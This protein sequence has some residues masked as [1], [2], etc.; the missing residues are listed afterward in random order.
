M[1]AL[2]EPSSYYVSTADWTA[3]RTRAAFEK[4]FLALL[5][6]AR[7]PDMEFCWSSEIESLLWTPGSQPAWASDRA[8]RQRFVEVYFK[9]IRPVLST[10]PI[11]SHSETATLSP[12]VIDEVEVTS[13]KTESLRIAASLV[14]SDNQFVIL[15]GHP[16][17]TR[18]AVVATT[19]MSLEVAVCCDAS[20]VLGLVAQTGR[21]WPRSGS[22]ANTL[23]LAIDV[24]HRS[25]S[26]ASRPF[27]YEYSLEKRLVGAL[28]KETR[29]RKA[30]LGALV[31]RL[32]MSQK[33]AHED[34]ALRD[35]PVRGTNLRR[36]CVGRSRIHYDYPAR[37]QIRFVEFFPAGHHDDGLR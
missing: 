27:R 36:L 22:D 3:E 21:L 6:L 34:K 4:R 2:L 30:M 28:S 26:F 5:D 18:A 20:G 19:A 7:L 35:H 16:D 8:G 14:A 17:Q 29:N 11:D 13:Y 25:G 15:L 9:R 33:E 37:S 31:K 1:K 12:D 32:C 23:R 10:V 24:S